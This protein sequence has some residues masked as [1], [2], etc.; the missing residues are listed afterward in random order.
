V[1]VQIDLG[2]RVL[3]AFLDILGGQHAVLL[4]PF[5]DLVDVQLSVFGFVFFPHASGLL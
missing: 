4:Q 3:P 5:D 2:D 1:F